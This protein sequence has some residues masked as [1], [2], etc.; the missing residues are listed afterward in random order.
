VLFRADVLEIVVQKLVKEFPE[1]FEQPGDSLPER[2]V[3]GELSAPAE[4]FLGQGRPSHPEGAS[5]SKFRNNGAKSVNSGKW[6][7]PP[8]APQPVSVKAVNP[9]QKLKK[10]FKGKAIVIPKIKDAP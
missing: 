1:I 8:K 7:I 6:A 9:S 10:F 2:Q 4:D 3:K 5:I